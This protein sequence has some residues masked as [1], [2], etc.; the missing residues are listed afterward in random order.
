MTSA[1]EGESSKSREESIQ[2]DEF[3]PPTF[4][5]VI[6]YKL[7]KIPIVGQVASKVLTFSSH[8]LQ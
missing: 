2:T 8:S 4:K 6:K 5:E 1:S 7:N 3:K